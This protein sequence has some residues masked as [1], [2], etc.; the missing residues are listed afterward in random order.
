MADS[1][2]DE[3]NDAEVARL[4][5]LEHVVGDLVIDNKAM[6]KQIINQR[7]IEEVMKTQIINQRKTEE[8]MKNQIA[9][10]IKTVDEITKYG[11]EKYMGRKIVQFFYILLLYVSMSTIKPHTSHISIIY[12]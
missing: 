2:E 12:K 5:H 6:K 4:D 10:L 9:R 1:A 3:L 11:N 7:N 8:G